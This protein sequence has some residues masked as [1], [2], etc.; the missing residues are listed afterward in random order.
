MYRW[1][2]SFGHEITRR[3]PKKLDLKDKSHSIGRLCP[4]EQG[5]KVDPVLLEEGA[6]RMLEGNPYLPRLLLMVPCQNCT[7]LSRPVGAEGL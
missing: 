6:H 2:S 7:L 4:S 3:R 5:G 1:A